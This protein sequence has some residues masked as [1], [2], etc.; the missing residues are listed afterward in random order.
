MNM[1]DFAKRA[2]PI[3]LVLGACAMLGEDYLTTAD[4]MTAELILQLEQRT[5][6][7]NQKVYV[8]EFQ[9]CE[10]TQ[11]GRILL[12]ADAAMANQHQLTAIRLRHAIIGNLAP[13]IPVLEPSLQSGPRMMASPFDADASRFKMAEEIGATAILT[14]S[15]ALE[16]TEKGHGL[17]LFLRIV[18]V[19]DRVILAAVDGIVPHPRVT[20]SEQADGHGEDL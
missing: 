5:D 15:F 18:S 17:L 19:E 10:R 4:D 6:I 20:A 13:L 8:V 12:V 7:R 11:D 14:G 1:K 16:D 2:L 9:P 3:L